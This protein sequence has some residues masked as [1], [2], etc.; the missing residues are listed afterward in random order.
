MNTPPAPIQ[1]L[2]R[3]IADRVFFRYDALHIRNFTYNS[4]AAIVTPLIWI[5]ST[6]LYL[7]L[8]GAEL[9]GIWLL[10]NSVLGIGGIAIA[11]QGQACVRYVSHY[12]AAGDSDAVKEIVQ[13]G[14]TLHAILGLLASTVIFAASDPIM[15]LLVKDA[16]HIREIAADATRIAAIGLFARSIDA[17]FHSSL[18]GFE[19]YDQAQ[20][21]NIFVNVASTGANLGIVWL[22]GG[23]S[24]IVL[25]T[26]IIQILGSLLKLRILHRYIGGFIRPEWNMSRFREMLPYSLKTWVQDSLGIAFGNADRI[27]CSML[28]GPAAVSYYSIAQRIVEQIHGLLSQAS[29]SFFPFASALH[30][31]GDLTALR[32]AYDSVSGYV[33][34]GAVGCLTPLFLF[35]DEILRLWID[36]DTAAA[37]AIA[38]RLFCIRFAFLSSG[39]VNYH[40]LMA[41]GQAGF[42][43]ILTI[44]Q[45]PLCIVAMWLLT[46]E[47]GVIGLPMGQFVSIPF[48]VYSRFYASR[49]IF[50]SLDITSNVALIS[51]SIIPICIAGAWWLSFSSISLTMLELTFAVPGSI[52]VVCLAAWT[53]IVACQ[54]LGWLRSRI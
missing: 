43:A 35:A 27:I 7:S 25:S 17:V 39:I 1:S 2:V 4:F 24:E 47:F 41:S 29:S 31:R 13:S 49:N 8:L 23:L 3:R 36:D 18:M 15:E 26:I 19:R 22:G 20:K 37:A 5:I 12:R 44:V 34:I 40:I 45:V 11:G 16:G 14:L 52:V 6:P 10:I 38:V 51:I 21:I 46:A 54:R 28:L 30:S 9:F 50:G 53:M 32:R 48:M 42:L 33:A